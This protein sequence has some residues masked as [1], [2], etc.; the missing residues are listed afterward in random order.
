MLYKSKYYYN[1]VEQHSTR[2]SYA[3]TEVRG[4]PFGSGAQS[5]HQACEVGGEV[6]SDRIARQHSSCRGQERKEAYDGYGSCRSL[7]HIAHD[8]TECADEICNRG[9]QVHYH[10]EEA[11]IATR[12]SQV[13]RGRR[14]KN[15]S[16]RMQCTAGRSGQ[17]DAA[18]AI[19][20]GCGVGDSSIHFTYACGSHF[21]KKRV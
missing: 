3:Y 8:S 18:A 9:A 7:Q 4:E 13:Y 15:H 20:K 1:F 12:P 5:A 10:A 2:Y 14:G 6:R 11:R 16:D 21:K 17:M 19:R